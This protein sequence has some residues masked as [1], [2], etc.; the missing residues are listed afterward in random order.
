MECYWHRT[1]MAPKT[2]TT[3]LPMK[4]E[5]PEWQVSHLKPR[6]LDGKFSHMEGR[7]YHPF[8]VL[9]RAPV[10]DSVQHKLRLDKV[11][12]KFFH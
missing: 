3:N 6:N 9:L 12:P 2:T 11:P 8:P 7:K 1:I 10:V 4:T 5:L